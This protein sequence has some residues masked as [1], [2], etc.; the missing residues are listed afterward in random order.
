MSSGFLL[1]TDKQNKAAYSTEFQLLHSVGCIRR[2]R[3]ICA[4]NAATDST[5]V[6]EGKRAEGRRQKANAQNANAQNANAQNANAQEANP[7]AQGVN[8]PAQVVN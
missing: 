8:P 4:T 6:A 5:L 1:G 3:W 7:P 2:R